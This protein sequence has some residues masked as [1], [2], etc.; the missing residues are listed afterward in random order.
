[1]HNQI[2]S[3]RASKI[4]LSIPLIEASADLSLAHTV[5]IVAREEFT[6]EWITRNHTDS[7]LEDRDQEEQPPQH[8]PIVSS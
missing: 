3:I 5:A 1:M 4:F 2:F 6:I 7:L 8:P